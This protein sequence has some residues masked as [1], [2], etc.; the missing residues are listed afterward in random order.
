[1]PRAV[2]V[3]TVLTLAASCA[4]RETVG[5][6]EAGRT[7]ALPYP[8]LLPLDTL[9]A[10]IEETRLEDNTAERLTARAA[11]LRL[12]AARLKGKVIAPGERRALEAAAARHT[13]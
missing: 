8:Q 11:A 3:L 4:P 6:A 13:P 9:L 5:L 1:M 2:L 12:K 10:G 7:A